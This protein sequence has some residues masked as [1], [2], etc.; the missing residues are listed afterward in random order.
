MIDADPLFLA[1][2]AGDF[3]LRADSPCIDTGDPA[4]LSCCADD[5]AGYPR[6]LDASLDRSLQVYV[7]AREMGH[8]HLTG[9]ASWTPG[10]TIVIET[11]ETRFLPVLLWA[12]TTQSKRCL[13]PFGGFAVD[14][15]ASWL[16]QPWTSI[17]SRVGVVIPPYTPVPLPLVLQEVAIAGQAANFSNPFSMTIQ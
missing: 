10:G 16:I 6:L 7:G 8:E 14:L 12:E 11:G 5:S 9:S 3:A 13:A 17:P 4:D 1:P 2:D 15:H